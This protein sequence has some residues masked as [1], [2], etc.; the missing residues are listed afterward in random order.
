MPKDAAIAI[1]LLESA[2]EL[3]PDHCAAHG[4]LLGLCSAPPSS[5]V[6][7]LRQQGSHR[8]TRTCRAAIILTAVTMRRRWQLQLKLIAWDEEWHHDGT[9]ASDRALEP[10]S[11]MF[12]P[13]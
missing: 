11:S 13:A 12:A 5:A 8:C 7:G 3:E 2:G 4:H 6:E 1:P 10:S 9:Q